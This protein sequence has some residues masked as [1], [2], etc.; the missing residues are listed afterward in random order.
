M[1]R[2]LRRLIGPALLGLCAGLAAPLASAAIVTG[3]WDPALPNPPFDNLGWTTTINLGIDDDCSQGAQSRAYII[4]V[5][6]RSFGCTTNPRE[7]T[8]PFSILSAQIGLYDLGTQRIIDVLTFDPA[9][10]T[11]LLLDLDDDGAISF[12][13]SITDSNAV[14]GSVAGRT[15]GFDFKLDLPGAAPAIRYRAAGSFGAFIR[16]PEIPIETAFEVTPDSALDDVLQRTQL[17]V[18]QPVFTAQVPEPGSLALAMLALLTMGAAG[19]GAA[20][21]RGAA[22]G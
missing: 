7:S 15:D 17:R 4:N 3:S 12:L 6:G 19:A 1:S 18:G 10:F 11:P 8:A 14:R 16:A 13:F 5:L 21:R 20:R 9:S 22:G 2:S